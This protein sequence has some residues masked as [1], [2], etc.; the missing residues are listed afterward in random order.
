MTIKR[1]IIG[2]RIW[3]SIVTRTMIRTYKSRGIRA[4]NMKG[5]MIGLV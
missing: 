3:I 5:I 4:K 2:I 1:I